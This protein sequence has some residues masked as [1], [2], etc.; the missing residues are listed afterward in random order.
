MDKNLFFSL[1][2]D[3]SKDNYVKTRDVKGLQPR[4]AFPPIF[5]VEWNF[6]HTIAS[7]DFSHPSIITFT[8]NSVT[9]PQQQNTSKLVSTASF[10]THQLATA[11]NFLF[12]LPVRLAPSPHP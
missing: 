11:T 10:D 4:S 6:R 12:K 8:L 7:L 1:S 9:H 2:I 3:I 5:P